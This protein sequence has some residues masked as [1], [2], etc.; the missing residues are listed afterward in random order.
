MK[1][2]YNKM[3]EQWLETFDYAT[4]LFHAGILIT[5]FIW[6]PILMQK[7]I[8]QVRKNRKKQNFHVIHG[9]KMN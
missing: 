5:A 6:L 9:G 3:I 8:K 2:G 7:R 4:L 1:R